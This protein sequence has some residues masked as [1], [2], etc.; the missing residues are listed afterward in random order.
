VADIITTG[1]EGLTE[2]ERRAER[3]LGTLT[4]EIEHIASDVINHTTSIEGLQADRKWI[5]ERIE[6]IARD[7]EALPKVPEELART[8]SEAISDLTTRV[9]RLEESATHEEPMTEPPRRREREEEN[10]ERREEK[11]DQSLLD[12]LF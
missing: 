11:Q 1:E 3:D 9:E 12:R 7:L 6:A 5:A 8:F 10:D 4:N 2:G